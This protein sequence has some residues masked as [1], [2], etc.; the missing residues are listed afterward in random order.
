MNLICKLALCMILGCL[1]YP[2]VWDSKRV[3]DICETSNKYHVGKCQVRWAY[4]LAVISIFDILIL[5]VL[6]LVLSRKQIS[7]FKISTIN[8]LDTIQPLENNTY[9]GEFNQFT[10]EKASIREFN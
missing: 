7:N 6:A 1:I 10:I 2:S 3:K 5:S 8:Y 9:Q 4:I